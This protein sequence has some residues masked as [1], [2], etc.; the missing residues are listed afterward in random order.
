MGVRET[1]S[2]GETGRVF[3]FFLTS[4]STLCTGVFAIEGNTDEVLPTLLV[5]IFK[6]VLRVNKGL[7]QRKNCVI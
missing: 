4:F 5:L 6:L 2:K 7:E 1:S 3:L